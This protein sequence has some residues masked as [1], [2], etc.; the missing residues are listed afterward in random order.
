MK[1]SVFN[2]QFLK[3]SWKPVLLTEIHTN[4]K[5]FK[6]FPLLAQWHTCTFFSYD[7]K[8][9]QYRDL[10]SMVRWLKENKILA[11]VTRQIFHS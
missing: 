10:I 11:K 8:W 5:Y 6:T 7:Q 1:H 9:R 3:S 4:I 2:I